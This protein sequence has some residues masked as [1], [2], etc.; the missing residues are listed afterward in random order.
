MDT[1]ISAGATKIA[2]KAEK[3]WKMERKGAEAMEKDTKIN[4]YGEG[5]M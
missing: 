4:A 2:G 5:R 3:C 1:Q